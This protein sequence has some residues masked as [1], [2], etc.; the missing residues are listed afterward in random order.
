[1]SV[2]PQT[3]AHFMVTELVTLP[4]SLEIGAALSQLLTKRISG[5]PVVD[6]T[7]ELV[8]ILT[9]KDCFRAALNAAYYKQWGGTVADYMSA[10]LETM[11]L[12]LDI[13]SAAERFL[14]TPYRRFPVLK[15]G[16]LVGLLS[17]SD[18]LA[19]FEAFS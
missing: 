3:I 13:V 4:P 14:A 11:D 6:D 8:G 18:L 2:E 17:R 12:E 16:Q 10:E 7:G 9:T 19:A 1:M 15:D 5:A